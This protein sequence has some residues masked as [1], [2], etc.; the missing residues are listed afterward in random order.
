[1]IE[2]F[3]ECEECYASCSVKHDLD[4]DHYT[5]RNACPFCDSTNVF[6]EIEEIR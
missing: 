3:I 6:I 4:I 5:V 2:V 1:M